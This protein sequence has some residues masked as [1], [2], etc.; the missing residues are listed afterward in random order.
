MRVDRDRP[1]IGHQDRIA[2]RRGV[3]RSLR[4]DVAACRC[5]I[6]HHNGLAELLAHI[7]RH[8]TRNGVGAAA[9]RIRYD[10]ANVTRRIIL[11][12]R[13]NDETIA[14]VAKRLLQ[15]RRRVIMVITP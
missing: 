10:K 7:M 11:R 14:G 2:V 13:L 9:G 15:N 1:L 4:C 8:Q 3:R 12:K 6:L 5:D